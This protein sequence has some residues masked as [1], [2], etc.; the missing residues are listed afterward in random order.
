MAVNTLHVFFQ[1]SYKVEA[2]INPCGTKGETES[3][4][5]DHKNDKHNLVSKSVILTICTLPPDKTL[6]AALGHR[7]AGPGPWE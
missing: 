4:T 5:Q 1:Q 2:T 7:K 3:L 6:G